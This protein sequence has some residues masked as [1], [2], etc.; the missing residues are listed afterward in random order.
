M[1]QDDES[2]KPFEKTDAPP[3]IPSSPAND[4]KSEGSDNGETWKPFE[5]VDAPAEVPSND[6]PDVPAPPPS[7]G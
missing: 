5:K 4:K 1:I 7:D 3:V 6:G 2:W